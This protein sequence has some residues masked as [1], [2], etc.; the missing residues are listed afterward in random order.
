MSCF[1]REENVYSNGRKKIIL[2]VGEK[3][4]VEVKRMFK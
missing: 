3:S 1:L 2:S 4:I